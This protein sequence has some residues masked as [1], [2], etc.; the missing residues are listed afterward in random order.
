MRLGGRLVGLG[1][2][3]LGSLNLRAELLQFGLRLAQPPVIDFLQPFEIAAVLSYWASCSRSRREWSSRWPNWS[4]AS[5][6][7]DSVA[8]RD[9][10]SCLMRHWTSSRCVWTSVPCL[11]SLAT[12]AASAW[13][14]AVRVMASN[15]RDHGAHRADQHRQE[16]EQRDAGTVLR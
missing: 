14:R 12:A 15:K 16:R 1:Q 9:C 5:A 3:L 8:A 6:T 7:W 10:F 2:L 4:R 13:S 11:A